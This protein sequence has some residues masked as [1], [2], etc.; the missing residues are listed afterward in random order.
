MLTERLRRVSNRPAGVS[1]AAL[2]HQVRGQV[3]FTEETLREFA[4]I[5]QEG[6]NGTLPDVVQALNAVEA[7]LHLRHPAAYGP[8]PRV[9]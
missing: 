3:R 4:A 5:P 8:V 1:L 6:A 9:G 2:Y 7:T